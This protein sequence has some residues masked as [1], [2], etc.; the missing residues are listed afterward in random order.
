[1]DLRKYFKHAAARLALRMSADSGKECLTCNVNKLNATSQDKLTK[2][3]ALAEYW[4]NIKVTLKA[5]LA[6]L[7]LE[8]NC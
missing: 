4:L 5:K 3:R 6:V 7:R 1:M 8:K 2:S